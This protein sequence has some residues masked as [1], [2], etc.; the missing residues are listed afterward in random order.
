MVQ[1]LLIML[2]AICYH[3]P[4]KKQTDGLPVNEARLIAIDIDTS[5]VTSKVK[6]ITL[7][8]PKV[9]AYKS[10]LTAR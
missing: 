7:M 3:S 2:R 10:I 5:P 8:T 1:T 4:T 9:Y 6:Y